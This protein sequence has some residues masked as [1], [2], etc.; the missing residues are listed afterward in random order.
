MATD[1]ETY[2]K[3]AI[4]G[5]VA[6]GGMFFLYK[7]ATAQGWLK[8]GGGLVTRRRGNMHSWRMFKSVKERREKPIIMGTLPPLGE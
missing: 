4:I 3:W 5:G 6:I 8:A 7:F 1:I 2:L